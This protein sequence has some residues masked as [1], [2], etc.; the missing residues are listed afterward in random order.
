M[1]KE[2]TFIELINSI[3]SVA[4]QGYDKNRKVIYWNKS[5]EIF[6]DIHIMKL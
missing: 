3:P 6:M 5:S 4:I 2:R 1:G